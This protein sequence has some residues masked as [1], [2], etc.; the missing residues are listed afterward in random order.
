MKNSVLAVLAVTA[1]GFGARAEEMAAPVSVAP[2]VTAAPAASLEL[3][4][5]AVGTGVE[6]REIVGEG[7]TF[8]EGQV[9][10]LT[11]VQ[12]TAAPTTLHHVYSVDGKEINDI[13]LNVNGS[14][15]RT[16][17]R[18]TVWPGAWKVEIKDDAGAVLKSIDF[19]VTAAAAAMPP[20]QP[21]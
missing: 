16:W 5:A 2:E 9:A 17:S 8:A 11:K 20:A 15:W 10:C 6:N 4:S 14:P 21:Q 3:L 1:L 12:T 13:A 7:T 19:E 18:K